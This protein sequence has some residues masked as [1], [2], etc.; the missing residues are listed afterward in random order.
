MTNT[1]NTGGYTTNINMD[2][3]SMKDSTKQ[4]ILNLKN[5]IP[6]DE[7]ENMTNGNG[8]SKGFKKGRKEYNAMKKLANM[9]VDGNSLDEVEESINK[10]KVVGTIGKIVSFALGILMV[11]Y[12]LKRLIHLDQLV[13]IEVYWTASILLAG[14]I[15]WLIHDPLKSL[16]NGSWTKRNQVVFSLLIKR[17]K[18]RRN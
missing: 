12:E 2:T 6:T 17:I 18:L 15:M 3:F 8:E 16:V 14:L 5:T 7:I 4:K 10:F 9:A 1:A 13:W 11:G